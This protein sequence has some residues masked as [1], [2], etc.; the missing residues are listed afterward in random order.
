MT[1]GH[2][3]LPFLASLTGL[4]FIAAGVWFLTHP[5][6]PAQWATTAWADETSES[7]ESSERS[8]S[9]ED[10]Y[11]DE[12]ADDQE[13]SEYVTKYR[14]VTN[15]ITVTEPGYDR[16]TDSDI[17]VDALDPDPARHQK[18]YFTDTDD[19]SIPDAFDLYHDEDDF[20][21]FESALDD[22]HNGIIDSLEQE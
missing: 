2:K 19:D 14:T 11:G 4:M 7:N 18:E 21:Y 5:F 3:L 17:V 12:E 8:G 16:D 15:I 9:G 20:S 22:D 13:K 1:A 10:G 6:E